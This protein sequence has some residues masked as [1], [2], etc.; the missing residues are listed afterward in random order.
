MTNGL[1]FHLLWNTEC[2]LMCMKKKGFFFFFLIFLFG[3]HYFIIILDCAKKSYMLPAYPIFAFVR[4]ACFCNF[5]HSES[6]IRKKEQFVSSLFH[7]A[8]NINSAKLTNGFNCFQAHIRNAFAVS[9]WLY[10][11]FVLRVFFSIFFNP[12]GF[13]LVI[14]TK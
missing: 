1:F 5:H 14:Y 3:S 10:H 13:E 6:M 9:S 8:I 12:R 11:F 2:T 7:S 4:L